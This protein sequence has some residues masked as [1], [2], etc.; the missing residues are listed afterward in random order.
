MS[1]REKIASISRIRFFIR[2]LRPE[3]EPGGDFFA[4]IHTQFIYT[5]YNYQKYISFGG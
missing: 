1:E 2:I 3:C 4:K 5:V